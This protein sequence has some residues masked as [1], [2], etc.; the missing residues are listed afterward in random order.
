VPAA[1]GEA[2]AAAAAGADLAPLHAYL[3]A[4]RAADFAIAPDTEAFL[5]QG[6]LLVP[7]GLA[8]DS[9]RVATACGNGP[10][11]AAA[12][13]VCQDPPA[14][15]A[16]PLAPTPLAAARRLQSWQGLGRRTGK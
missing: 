16:A 2:A 10:S 3:A 7:A 11:W 15:R 13:P 9:A 14:R 12:R 5:Q 8:C 1:N 6:A 4:A